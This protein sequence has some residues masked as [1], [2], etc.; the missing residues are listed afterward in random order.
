MPNKPLPALG[1]GGPACP[2]GKSVTLGGSITPAML[3]PC[4]KL[5][6]ISTG[7]T[8]IPAA[9]LAPVKAN[10]PPGTRFANNP[11]RGSLKTSSKKS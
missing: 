3:S 9:A 4:I 6:A 10:V 5:V 1:T 2:E 8:S 11:I 7:D